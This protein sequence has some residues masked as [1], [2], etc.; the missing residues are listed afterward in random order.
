MAFVSIGGGRLTTWLNVDYISHID[1]WGEDG[2]FTVFLP[3]GDHYTVVGEAQKAALL[4]AIA[5]PKPS[6]ASVDRDVYDVVGVSAATGISA[7]AQEHGEERGVRVTVYTIAAV[8][9]MVIAPAQARALAAILLR[10][11]AKVE[12]AQ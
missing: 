3:N 5:P 9:S 1:I 8:K 10:E 12:A 4:A 11:A 2:D 7:A 6:I